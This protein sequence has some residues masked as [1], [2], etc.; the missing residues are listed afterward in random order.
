MRTFYQF[1]IEADGR[2][3]YSVGEWEQLNNLT[4][5]LKLAND[6]NVIAYGEVENGKYIELY[7]RVYT[8]N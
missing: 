2:P 3:L 7:E 8:K 6:K 1:E 5:D 4:N